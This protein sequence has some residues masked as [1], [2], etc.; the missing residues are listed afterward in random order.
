MDK[1]YVI[2]SEYYNIYK[3]L[4]KT[5]LFAIKYLILISELE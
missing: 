1:C 4:D 5:L 3:Y 2:G